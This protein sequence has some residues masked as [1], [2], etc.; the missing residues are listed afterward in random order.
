MILYT[1]LLIKLP[2]PSFPTWFQP[3]TSTEL[4][5]VNWQRGLDCGVF[6]IAISTSSGSST[7]S[8]YD[9]IWSACYAASSCGMFWERTIFSFSNCLIVLFLLAHRH[10]S[11]ST[12]CYVYQFYTIMTVKLVFSIFSCSVHL[13][14]TLALLYYYEVLILFVQYWFTW[15]WWCRVK[16]KGTACM[17]IMIVVCKYN[18]EWL[19]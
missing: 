9:H 14:H 10:Y 8:I 16:I 1:V 4:I 2:R 6:A 11:F 15:W 17:I 12:L 7:K 19:R 13:F 5:P 18:R 3:L